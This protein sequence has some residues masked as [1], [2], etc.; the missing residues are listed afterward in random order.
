MNAPAEAELRR[1]GIDPEG[2]QARQLIGRHIDTADLVLTATSEQFDF[3]ESAAPGRDVARCSYS[4][5]SAV[6]RRR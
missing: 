4:A 5:S 1:R 3:V 6:W 2:F